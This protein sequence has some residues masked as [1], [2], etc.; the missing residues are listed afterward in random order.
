[1]AITPKPAVRKTASLETSN[2]ITMA[3]NPQFVAEFKFLKPLT[4]RIAATTSTC[5][6]CPGEQAASVD[7]SSIVLG[8]KQT[9]ASMGD[10]RKKK[11][12]QMLQ[13]QKVRVTYMQGNK[14]V[15]S[16]F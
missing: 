9:I 10:D 6:T 5:S 4:G 1:M 15:Q 16:I 12:K 7:L 8:I 3:N 11:L 2:L 13:A 14:V